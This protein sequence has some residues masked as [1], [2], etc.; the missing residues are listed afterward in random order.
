LLALAVGIGLKDGLTWLR[1]RR[2]AFT[3]LSRHRVA[4]AVLAAIFGIAILS[5][6][7]YYQVGVEKKL[8][9]IYMEGRYGPFLEQIR[10]SG[11]TKRLIILDYGVHQVVLGEQAGPFLHYSP[12]ADFY[13][14]VEDSRGMQVQVAAPGG[15]LPTGSWIASCDPRSQAWLAD[16]Y[17][18]YIASQPNSW[19]E[20][21]RTG[22]PR[23]AALPQ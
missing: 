11:L 21:E 2:Q 22:D 6:L 13:A 7:Y 14:K 17:T 4:Y 1:V 9:G 23:P 5:T 16:H 20:L 12:E 19:C 18:V 15:D 3:V 10:H 8:A